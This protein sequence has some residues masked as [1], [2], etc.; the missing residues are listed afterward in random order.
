[1]KQ[2]A[3]K[4]TRLKVLFIS[5]G[6]AND[7]MGHVIR[8]RSVAVIMKEFAHVRMVVIGDEYVDNL[9]IGKDVDYT[10]VAND[11]QVG[12][13]SHS[14]NPEII[15]YDM[16]YFDEAGFTLTNNFNLTVSLSPIFNLLP[17][18]DLIFHR[19]SI[20]N[21]EWS[22]FGQKPV[23]KAGLE[24]AIINGHCSKINEDV[25]W[26]NLKHERLAIA[27]SMGGTDAANKALQVLETIKQIEG[28]L[29]IWLLLGEGYSHSYQNLVDC[30]RNSRHE[31]ILAKTNESMWRILS[32]CSLAVL[33]GGTTTYEAVY[34]GLPSINM[35]QS[36]DRYFLIREL[37]EKGVCICAGY[38][39]E[40]SLKA[41]NPL[42]S[43]FNQNRHEL[44][45]MLLKCKD[46]ID[47]QGAKRIIDE[48]L[49][50]YWKRRTLLA[51]TTTDD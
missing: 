27:I 48:T 11:K 5:R 32:T 41:L 21:K 35:L 22:T 26:E 24:Y 9:L 10:I 38:T 17:K 2:R 25:Y 47:D 44:Y 49:K 40:Q 46:L 42:L 7:G 31:I 51:K 13:I 36:E 37:V 20:R 19:T 14:F 45:S 43:Q 50:Y 8:S 12:D 30:M 29:L 3:M 6:S 15:I 4:D 18:T 33:A 1:M 34:A 28:R 39:F 16:T 23:V